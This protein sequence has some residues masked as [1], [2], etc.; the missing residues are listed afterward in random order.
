M[1]EYDVQQV[2]DLQHEGRGLACGR[3]AIA[4]VMLALQQQ[5]AKVTIE[6]YAT[7]GDVSGD[8]ARVVGYAG[9]T[10]TG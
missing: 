10:F 3:G 8:M 7:S 6:K 4:T 2:I 5:Q 1:V 9:A